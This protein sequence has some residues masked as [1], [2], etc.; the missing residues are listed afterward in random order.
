MPGRA[1]FKYAS[2]PPTALIRQLADRAETFTASLQSSIQRPKASQ[3]NHRSLTS[4][5][6]IHDS[7]IPIQFVRALVNDAVADLVGHRAAGCAV[8]CL[9]VGIA[10]GLYLSLVPAGLRAF[11]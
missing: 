7:P 3:A 2:S 5:G 9:L 8:T 1:P 10:G 11:W 4:L 6:S